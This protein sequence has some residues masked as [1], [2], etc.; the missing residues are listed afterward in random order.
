MTTHK[1]VP[2]SKTTK[3]HS[4][5]G[6]QYAFHLP[7]Q[8]ASKIEALCE[9]HPHKTRSQLIEDLLNLGLTEIERAAAQA[10]TNQAEIH[11][12][13]SQPIY[14]LTGPFSE[15]HGLVFKHHNAMERA[16]DSDE[17]D[18]PYLPDEYTLDDSK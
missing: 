17:V 18:V 9:I 15:F 10:S 5:R 6:K 14:L 3:N 16:L 7:L 4:T 8:L 13:T 11:A 2:E 1:N 12:D